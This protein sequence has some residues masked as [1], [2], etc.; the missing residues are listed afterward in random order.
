MKPEK[1][2]KYRLRQAAKIRGD[3]TKMRTCARKCT[4]LH[5]GHHH[6]LRGGTGAGKKFFGLVECAESGGENWFAFKFRHA[7]SPIR[8]D[9]NLFRSL[10]FVYGSPADARFRNSRLFSLPL[11]YMYTRVFGPECGLLLFRFRLSSATYLKKIII[12]CPSFALCLASAH[13]HTAL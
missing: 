5:G 6:G 1:Y 8:R 4:A 2:S 9:E 3:K 13:A 10:A 7:Q 12:S 11:S